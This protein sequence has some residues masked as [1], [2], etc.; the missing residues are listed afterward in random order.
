M[1]EQEN[2]LSIGEG[3]QEN[4]E[5][6][7]CGPQISDASKSKTWVNSFIPQQYSWG[8]FLISYEATCKLL[9]YL[10]VFPAFINILRAFGERAGFDDESHSEISF[11][12][13]ERSSG[14]LS[15]WE[16]DKIELSDR[17]ML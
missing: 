7:V 9:T 16:A 10:Q 17:L 14:K 1:I 5:S 4:H 12:E 3:I 11:Q 6:I 13:N 2:L 8:R 15:N